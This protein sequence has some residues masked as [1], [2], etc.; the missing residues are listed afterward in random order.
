MLPDGWESYDPNCSVTNRPVECGNCDW[1]GHEDDV[2]DGIW[3][4]NDICDRLDAG[5]VVPVGVCPARHD[6]SKDG[7]Y[8]CGSLVYYSDT[9]IAYRQTPTILDKIVEATS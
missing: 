4:I 9:E 7:S 8:P 3:G 5:S 6:D 2:P 1:K